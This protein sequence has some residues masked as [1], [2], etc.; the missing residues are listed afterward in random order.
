MNGSLMC[1]VGIYT[2][3]VLD[4]Y[5]GKNRLEVIIVRRIYQDHPLIQRLD[6]TTCL[7]R[8]RIV[9]LQYECL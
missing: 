3:A 5:R 6:A 7:C 4:S 2:D 9:I 8:C 1:A